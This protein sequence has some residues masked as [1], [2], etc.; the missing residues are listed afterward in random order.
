MST[1]RIAKTNDGSHDVTIKG[2]RVGNFDTLE[3]A[4][5]HVSVLGKEFY[6]DSDG[7]EYRISNLR[8]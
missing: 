5:H 4:I 3:Q 6:S 8:F 7:C 2:E 1:P